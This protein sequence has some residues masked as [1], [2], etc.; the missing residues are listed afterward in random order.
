MISLRDY[1]LSGVSRLRTSIQK[2]KRSILVAPTGAGKTRM[3][4]RIMQGAIE[5]ENRVWFIVH[6]RELCKQTSKALWEAKVEHGM[7]MSGKRRSPVLAQV[8]TVITAANLIEKL[9]PEQRPKLIIFDE[10]HRSV[11]NSYARIAEACPDAYIIGLTATPERTD[12]RGLGELY[13][14][15][16]EVQSMAWLIE[17][18]YLA[19]YKLIA[20]STKRL[21]LSSVKTKGG[22]YD[23]LQLEQIM[24]KPTITGDAIKAYRQFANGKR[25]MVFCVS[26]KHSQ[27][28]CE[29]Y[30][31]AGIKAEH[32][33]GNHTDAQ[34][35][36]A[37]ERFRK[38]ETLILCSVQLAI[39]GLDIPAVEA[40]QQLR[41]TQ[42]VIVYLQLI[43][44]GLRPEV[45]KS[46][47]IIL[48]QVNNWLRHGLPCDEREWSLEGRKQ[49]RRKKKDDEEASINLYQCK[50]CF[51]VFKKGVSECPNCHAPVEASGRVIEQVDGSLSEIDLALAKKEQRR[52]QGQARTLD[53]LVRLGMQRGMNKPAAWAAITLAARQGKKPM[54]LDFKNAKDVYERLN[55]EPDYAKRGAF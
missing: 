19:P 37:L 18:K 21:D 54:P 39:E 40:V 35:E 5:Q 32:I 47:L 12:G 42:S 41:P 29:Q 28:T 38:G 50:E 52:A 53:D 45:G 6:R 14:D 36:A 23:E 24:D 11:S 30:N 43:G 25:C 49:R 2:H 3:A 9:P 26:I 22:D 16:V 20:P 46:H 27:H 51:H 33:D 48:D 4:I 10:S 34:R 15:M 44:R 7:I 17:N 55:S 31:N 1:Q 8:G 13:S